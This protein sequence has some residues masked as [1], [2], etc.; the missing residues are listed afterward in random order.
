MID[1]TPGTRLRS[2]HPQR[3]LFPRTWLIAFAVPAMA[4]AQ[5]VPP[6][7][8]ATTPPAASEDVIVLTPFTVDTT[9]DRGYQAENTLSGSRLNSSLNDTPASVSVFT[10]EFLQDVGLTELN[11]LVDYSVN[12]QLNFND[13]SSATNAN[14]YVNA[15]ALVRKIDIRGIPSSQGL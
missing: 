11:E 15:T 9:K 7:P 10:K 2:S 5:T 13:M 4:L 1:L 8:A 6:A 14:P 3:R 12:A